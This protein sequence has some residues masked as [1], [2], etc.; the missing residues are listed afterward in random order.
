M[1]WIQTAPQLRFLDPLPIVG[2]SCSTTTLPAAS[3]QV[4]TSKNELP[5]ITVIPGELP[6]SPDSSFVYL[7]RFLYR[8]VL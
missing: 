6:P 7:D 4:A 5:S 8:L 1:D 3:I 2:E